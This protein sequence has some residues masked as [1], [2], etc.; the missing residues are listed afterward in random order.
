[1]SYFRYCNINK[2]RVI[3]GFNHLASHV[4]VGEMV[5]IGIISELNAIDNKKTRKALT[6]EPRI[7]TFE[8]DK[9]HITYVFMV[10]R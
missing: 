6:C 5:I 3:R 10:E 7:I 1:M 2:F 8:H 4:A 9:D